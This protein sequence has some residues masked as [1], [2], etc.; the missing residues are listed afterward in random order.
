MFRH[1]VSR[2]YPGFNAWK[3]L[4]DFIGANTDEEAEKVS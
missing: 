3:K 4:V 1:F 2:E